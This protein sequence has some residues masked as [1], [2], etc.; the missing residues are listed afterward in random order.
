MSLSSKTSPVE[1]VSEE[2]TI[3]KYLLIVSNFV[4]DTEIIFANNP[5][6]TSALS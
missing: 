1:T 5:T 3:D 4:P 2:Y 6:K